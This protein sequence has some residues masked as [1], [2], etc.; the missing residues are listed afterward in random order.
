LYLDVSSVAQ[1]DDRS[2][3]QR[4]TRAIAGELLRAGPPDMRIEL[5][6]SGTQDLRFCAANRYAHEMFGLDRPAGDEHVDFKPGDILLFLD[7]HPGVAIAH[8]DFT[9]YLRNKGVAVFHVVY[10]LLPLRRP[11]FFWPA[12]CAEFRH[13]VATVACA[14]GALCISRAV[15]D[16]LREALEAEGLC[17]TGGFRIGWFHLG[18]D[19]AS[20]APSM[21]LPADAATVL[22]TLRARP[23]FLMV[24]TIEPRKG[25]R[26]ALAA[27]EQLWRHGVAA[28]LVIVGRAGW[29]MQGF[30]DTLANHAEHG[31]RLFCLQGIS[32][33][34]LDRVYEASACLLAASEG[35]GF[36]LPLIEAARHG[37]ALLARDLPV[38]REVAGD[39]ADYFADDRNPTIIAEAVN[40]WI[41]ARGDN[42]AARGSTM[43]WLTWRESA[44]QLL[45]R[46]LQ[47]EWTYRLE[48]A[49]PPK[50]GA[51][52]HA[53]FSRIF[54]GWRGLGGLHRSPTHG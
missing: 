2:G 14:S 31:R 54:K 39:H 8:R 32:D 24:G 40:R 27:F 25:H 28:N 13:W 30:I 34:Y 47:D 23:S 10:D 19:I 1:R 11:E 42:G 16:E 4:V 49:P 45:D 41:A 22:A 5:V 3:I 18:A 35:E 53:V 33:E 50:P 36:G 9:R 15:A 44:T 21:G 37:I 29:G 26:Q 7:L 6:H 38:F 48:A 20:S 52:R 43:T 51:R 17:R 12:L 46:L